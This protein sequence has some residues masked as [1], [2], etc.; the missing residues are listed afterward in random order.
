M[1]DT[2]GLPCW[3]RESVA[4]AIKVVAPMGED[5]KST[6]YFLA[7]H[8]PVEIIA[9]ELGGGT[10]SERQLFERLLD[11]SNANVLA[12]VQ[13]EPG[14][15]KSH[16]IRWLHLQLKSAR[17]RSEH[18]DMLPVLVERRT[19]SL[20]DA[21]LQMLS[22]LPA[23]FSH[24]MER[25]KEAISNISDATARQALANQ[26]QLEL[27][28]RWDERHED[29]LPAGFRQVNALCLSD[30]FRRWL[31]RDEGC[32]AANVSRLTQ[33]SDTVARM[34]L[35]EFGATEFLLPPAYRDNNVAAVRELI[36]ELDDEVAAR[37][38]VAAL[39]NRALRHAIKEMSGLGGTRL[40]DMFDEIRSDLRRQ[41]RSLA[42][43]IEDIT[44]MSSLDED[45]FSAVEPQDRQDLCRLIAVLG[46][47]SRGL[48]VALQLRENQW[49]RVTHRVSVGGDVAERWK[50]DTTSV[51]RFVGRYLNAVRLS[52]EDVGRTAA[53]RLEGG[54]VALSACTNC[55]VRD[56]CHEVFGS[57]S[58][59]GV[60][61]GLF[62]FTPIAPQRL[63]SHLD[64]H[65]QGIRQNQRGLLERILR[66]VLGDT[67]ALSQGRF[68]SVRLAVAL[69]QPPFWTA[70]QQRYC[71]GWGREDVDRL[72]F[73]CQAWVSATSSEE[74][75]RELAAIRE[76]F[77]LP[78]F[79][80]EAP[81][82]RPDD[83]VSPP[84]PTEPPDVRPRAR[85]TPDELQ[86]LLDELATWADGGRLDRDV[87]PRELLQHFI[88]QCVSWF[89][90]RLPHNLGQ[91]LFGDRSAVSLEEQS[92]RVQA[93]RF[94]LTFPLPD[95]T[96]DVRERRTEVKMVLEALARFRYEGS[97]RT[98]AFTDG[99][100][101][102][103][104][105]SSWL[106]RNEGRI[107][108]ACE[109]AHGLD[110]TLPIAFAG[111]ILRVTAL[112]R[113]KAAFPPDSAAIFRELLAVPGEPLHSLSHEEDALIQELTTSHAAVRDF[114][115]SELSIPQGQGG[116]VNFI[117]PM[118]LLRVVQVGLDDIELG[119]LPD[120]YHSGY[121]QARYQALRGVQTYPRL[122]VALEAR[123]RALRE[124]SS[125]LRAT[126][127]DAGLEDGSLPNAF[128]RFLS[129]LS[130]LVGTQSAVMPLPDAEF[131]RVVP[132]MRERAQEWRAALARMEELLDKPQPASVD[133]LTLDTAPIAEVRDVTAVCEAFLRR[134]DR[135]LASQEAGSSEGDPIEFRDEFLS[136]LET[137][138]ALARESDGSPAED[139]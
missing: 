25:L 38:R 54:E 94:T 72:R 80:H 15:G 37:E 95:T 77:R 133:L 60:E 107:I 120:A 92:A 21:L 86:T 64:E 36:D 116:V 69:S 22:Q 9:D 48:H 76:V 43:F 23:E 97:G 27:G 71:G 79:S 28:P 53:Q 105:L 56:N 132:L 10:L 8:A 2:L 12:I 81:S 114:L 61:V 16:L 24:H 91:K 26:L 118:P 87:I 127:I 65:R 139:S 50:N 7:T 136:A 128:D 35:P 100:L 44:V 70:F 63:V 4:D 57:V 113:R 108:K 129:E 110:E 93:G 11:P 82:A 47:A 66:P 74:A 42:L 73:L 102:K 17:G 40:R 88:L 137:I 135:E 18:P 111:G 13:G 58:Y 19:G 68:P 138:V 101:H 30:G 109:L 112:L 29:R 83:G 123:T 14:S 1:P 104:V 117:D 134:L 99:E 31:L 32:I 49:G 34:S 39:F 55:A 45:V 131:E 84:P 98:W 126:M 106:R 6:Q 41:G 89:D 3:R 122:R 67:G 20:K 5:E 33:P 121:W 115:L 96:G 75:A 130:E 52:T 90:Y 124:V 78:R 103:R 59:E 85:A 46:V 51:A 125:T 62:P 119:P